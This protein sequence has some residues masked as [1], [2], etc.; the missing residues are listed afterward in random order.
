MRIAILSAAIVAA[1]T[2]AAFAQCNIDQ[3]ATTNNA[4]MAH[5]GQTDLAQSFQHQ[6][7]NSICGAGIFLQPGIGGTDNVTIDLWTTLP[8]GGGQMLASGSA[9]GTAGNWVDVTWTPVAIQANTTYYLH[10]HGNVTLGISGDVTNQYPY[11]QVY[12][13]PGFQPFPNFDYTFRTTSGAAGST[14]RISGQ[15]PGQVTVSWSNATPSRPMGIVLGNGTGSFN[16]PGGPCAGTQLGI[17]GGLQLVYTGN[18]GASGSG[19][20]SSN[21]GTAACRK[22]LQMVIVDGSPCDTTNVVQIP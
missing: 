3:N 1:S 10:F 7:S 19:Q 12:A 17:A 18:T 6:V 5:F 13:N 2:G 20:V 15:C 4:Y 22:Y 21:A 9:Q 16:I 14:L 8:N 11:G